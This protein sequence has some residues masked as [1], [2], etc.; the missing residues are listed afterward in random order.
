MEKNINSFI[1]FK[2]SFQY[3]LLFKTFSQRFGIST[4][5]V[6]IHLGMVEIA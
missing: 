1:I 6:G 2:V 4:P 3:G 5:K